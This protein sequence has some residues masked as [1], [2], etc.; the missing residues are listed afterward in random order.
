ML[1]IEHIYEDFAVCIDDNGNKVKIPRDKLPSNASVND[2]LV[3]QN[4]RYYLDPAE[5]KRRK[6]ANRTVLDRMDA[7]SRRESIAQILAEA[8]IPVSASSL[9]DRFHVSRQII[10]GD[11]A[12]L[13]AS[14][15]LVIAT[16]RGYL[17]ERSKSDDSI[18]EYTIAC[19]HNGNDLLLEELYTVVDNGATV[20]DVI[21]EHPVYG[22]LTGLLQ[23]SSR[24]DADRFMEMLQ[25]SN[26]APLSQITDGIHLHTIHCPDPERI[27]YIKKQLSEK[28]IL[29][30]E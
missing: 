18:E 4:T 13:R 19:C 5:T 6:S 1:S 25:T 12:L 7:R 23:V 16:P 8:K 10:V 17:I 22:Q 11:I 24:Y 29:V 3:M 30:S 2:I 27:K 20:V 15:S 28:G 21:V 14:G 26:A 9:A